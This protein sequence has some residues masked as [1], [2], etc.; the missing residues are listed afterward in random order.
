M[1]EIKDVI[2][3]GH[4]NQPSWDLK[5]IIEYFGKGYF[6][7]WECGTD[8]ITD[9]NPFHKEIVEIAHQLVMSENHSNRYQ[10]E[11]KETLL[12]LIVDMTLMLLELLEF[13]NE[14]LRI[15]FAKKLTY[16]VHNFLTCRYYKTSKIN[17]MEEFYGKSK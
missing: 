2:C 11:T 8:N 15:E 7:C 3:G 5:S 1:I 4:S 13:K 14:K 16:C 9:I 12:N 6:Q 10:E 17:W